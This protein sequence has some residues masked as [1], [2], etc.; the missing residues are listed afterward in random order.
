ML[1]ALS[2]LAARLPMSPR[3]NK[4]V[5]GTPKCCAVWFPPLR[6]GAGYFQRWPSPL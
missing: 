5:N 6:F 2:N 4:S 3:A 1:S